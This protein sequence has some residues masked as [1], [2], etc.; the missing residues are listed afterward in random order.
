MSKPNGPKWKSDFKNSHFQLNFRNAPAHEARP[1]WV[2]PPTIPLCKHPSDV[3]TSI[4]A[5]LGIDV[6]LHH[7]DAED[8]SWG[9]GAEGR[10]QVP[11]PPSF[12]VLGD[13]TRA[14]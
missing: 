4:E 10:P 12:S 5:P 2:H 3:F 9:P 6:F 8:G 11:N 13:L 7:H 1:I 14:G